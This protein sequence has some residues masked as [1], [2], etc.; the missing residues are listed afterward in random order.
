MRRLLVL[1]I[2]SRSFAVFGRALSSQASVHSYV[3]S[4]PPMYVEA[5][6]KLVESDWDCWMPRQELEATRREHAEHEAAR[7]TSRCERSATKTLENGQLSFLFQSLPLLKLQ[8]NTGLE[9]L[10][11]AVEVETIKV[12]VA[13]L[14]DKAHT[15]CQVPV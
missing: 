7:R 14:E 15:V 3:G 1:S 12:P 10:R 2:G 13:I 5:D 6:L 9:K 4:L 11:I 8:L